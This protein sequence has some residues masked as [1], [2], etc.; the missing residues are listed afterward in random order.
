MGYREFT[1]DFLK[2]FVNEFSRGS[3]LSFLGNVQ[4]EVVTEKTRSISVSSPTKRVENGFNISDTVRKNPLLFS[5]TVVDNSDDYMQNRQELERIQ[6]TGEVTTFFFNGRDIYENIIIEN[7]EEIETEAQSTGFT[8]HISLKQ[9]QIGEVKESD[10]K[11]DSGKAK[12]TG[13]KKKKTSGKVS[14]ATKA[15]ATKA[16]AA[17]N[18]ST[19]K[20]K[21]ALKNIF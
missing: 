11:F 4:L 3:K 8:Y 15:E 1:E 12:S 18:N 19:K 13:G 21:S 10:I 14:K 2:G 16:A 9:I 20:G 17:S 6:A 5:I 7:V